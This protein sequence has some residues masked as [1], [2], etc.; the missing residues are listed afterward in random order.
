MGLEVLLDAGY[1][2]ILHG[3]QMDGSVCNHMGNGLM[4]NDIYWS[5]REEFAEITQ[6]L[7]R[8]NSE[9]VVGYRRAHKNLAYVVI[10]NAG[11]LVPMNQPE[12]YC[13]SWTRQFLVGLYQ[14][15][16]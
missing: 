6:E 3:G 10:V 4:L 1:N 9:N 2:V 7:W 16:K 11:H 12:N 13:L 15:S 5:G 14:R 8:V